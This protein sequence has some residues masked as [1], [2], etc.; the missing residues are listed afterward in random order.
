VSTDSF[1]C[2]DWHPAPKLPQNNIVRDEEESKCF[3]RVEAPCLLV[4]YQ[5]IHSHSGDIGP[6]FK[7]SLV[8]SY[9][10]LNQALR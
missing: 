3:S 8:P 2:V 9:Y 10:N 4:N 1:L 6:V 7:P 5:S